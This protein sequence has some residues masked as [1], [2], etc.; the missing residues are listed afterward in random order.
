MIENEK[1]KNKDDVRTKIIAGAS[2]L[3]FYN[4]IKRV[5]M[6]DI[7]SDLNI[8]KRTIYEQFSDKEQLLTECLKYIY[9]ELRHHGRTLIKGSSRNTLDVILILYKIYFDMLKRANRNF[10][11]DVKKYPQ[12]IKHQQRRE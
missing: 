8:S 11:I 2:K 7:A 4:G 6:D 9:R 1:N 12:I 10:F 3:F 5:K